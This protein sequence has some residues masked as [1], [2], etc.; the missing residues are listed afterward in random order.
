MYP[1]KQVEQYVS[2]FQNHLLEEIQTGVVSAYRLHNP[3]YGRL[4]SCLLLDTPEGFVIMG[5]LSPNG[6][7]GCTSNFGYKLAWFAGNLSI[8][9]LLEKV[10][11]EKSWQ[12]ELALADLTE[13]LESLVENE[14]MSEE[15]KAWAK[16][17]LERGMST[18]EFTCQDDMNAYFDAHI[19]A[20]G[21]DKF[22]T[23]EAAE[24]VEHWMEVISP[25]GPSLNDV[26]LLYTIQK[27]FSEL[28]PELIK[29]KATAGE[30]NKKAAIKL[31]KGGFY[32]TAY[33]FLSET[34][35]TGE[36]EKALNNTPFFVRSDVEANERE[37]SGDTNFAFTEEEVVNGLT[38]TLKALGYIVRQEKTH[39]IYGHFFEEV[40]FGSPECANW[41]V[42]PE[43]GVQ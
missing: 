13:W 25:W 12:P 33:I 8:N 36:V 26:A 30:G 27:R 7:H 32:T 4:E 38:E 22:I 21:D 17:E 19:S 29:S 23:E 24:A 11:L 40:V 16:K 20:W 10:H 35:R 41:R 6:G 31:Q 39:H 3:A 42:T 2:N 15:T 1:Q 9:Y 5:D 14:Y 43:E 28:Y 18:D 37:Y 34:D